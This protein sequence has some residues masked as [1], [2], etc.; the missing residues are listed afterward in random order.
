MSNCSFLLTS[1][2]R[3]PWSFC[4]KTSGAW[5]SSVDWGGWK[6]AQQGLGACTLQRGGWVPN[7]GGEPSDH[8]LEVSS[9]VP[10]FAH[11]FCV[12]F[13]HNKEDRKT[14]SDWAALDLPPCLKGRE[15]LN[16]T[17]IDRYLCET[18]MKPAVLPVVVGSLLHYTN[19]DDISVPQVKMQYVMVV[20]TIRA[21]CFQSQTLLCVTASS[22]MC[23]AQ[24]W[25]LDD[26]LTVGAIDCVQ[27]QEPG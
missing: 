25:D 21:V 19:K 10:P 14:G 1:V 3:G 26:T 27:G 7:T 9:G 24:L 2:G 15:S 12:L 8:S 5:V 22:K 17:V 16:V 20:L 18:C 11:P 23:I 13:L 4:W 6:V